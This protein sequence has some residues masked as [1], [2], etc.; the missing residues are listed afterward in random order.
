VHFI[1]SYEIPQTIMNNIY[2]AKKTCF[3]PSDIL[4]F[5]EAQPKRKKG[6]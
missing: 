3:L 1:F 4:G 2:Y 6:L 5:A